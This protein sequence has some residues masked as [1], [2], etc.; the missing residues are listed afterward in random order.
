MRW[1]HYQWLKDKDQSKNLPAHCSVSAKGKMETTWG[2]QL[3][4]CIE[5]GGIW[6]T[7]L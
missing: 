7:S 3:T 5:T 6:D 1:N 4:T 2:S